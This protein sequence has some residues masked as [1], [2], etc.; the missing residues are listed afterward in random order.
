MNKLSLPNILTLFRI[1]LIPFFVLFFYLPF[2]NHQWVAVGIYVIASLT[3]WLDGFLARQLKQTSNFGEFL[4]PVAD[5]L[6]ILSAL[7]LCAS[8]FTTPL[9]TIPALVILCRE[10]IIS[11]LRAWMSKYGK[12][13]SIKVNLIAKSKTAIQMIAIGFLISQ[14]DSPFILSKLL[15]IGYIL[16]YIA[17]ILT[18]WSML[19]YINLAIENMHKKNS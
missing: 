13:F 11:A 16:F 17:V 14:I 2:N 7:L 6:M 15:V 18:V 5:K 10:I 1:A 3:D 9:F 19:I 4:D 8:K 12:K